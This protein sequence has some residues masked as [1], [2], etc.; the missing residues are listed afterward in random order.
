MT[1]MHD[2]ARLI[3]ELV[4]ARPASTDDLADCAAII[5]DYI[6][7]TP[8]LPRT[9]DRAATEALFSPELLDKRTIFVAEHERVIV[10]YLSLDREAAFVHALYLRPEARGHGVGKVMLNAAK[11]ICPQ[12]LELTIFEPN[13]R[14][15][16]FYVREGF[17]E[18]PEGRKE[19]TE[20]GVPTL[21]MRWKNDDR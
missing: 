9:L 15:F 1:R 7:D 13:R 14:A 5:N 18:V 21:L 6:D 2:M 19:D 20:E 16:R 17:I 3:D 11:K 8:W 12:G 4:T 10:G